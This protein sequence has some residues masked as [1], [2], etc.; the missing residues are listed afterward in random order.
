M[1]LRTLA[2]LPLCIASHVHTHEQ[3][4]LTIPRSHSRITTRSPVHPSHQYTVNQLAFARSF[5][6]LASNSASLAHCAPMAKVVETP[7][8]VAAIQKDASKLQRKMAKAQ[9]AAVQSV[10]SKESAA[11]PIET[12]P[13]A[14]VQS[15]S[16]TASQSSDA[17]AQAKRL[18]KQAKKDRK[19]KAAE[20]LEST[21]SPASASVEKPSV[22]Q[23]EASAAAPAAHSIDQSAG[24]EKDA[25]R[26]KADKKAAKKAAKAA[27]AST[28]TTSASAAPASVTSSVTDSAAVPV[29]SADSASTRPNFYKPHPSILALSESEVDAYRT[30]H[31]M[32]IS[33]SSFRPIQT[34]EQSG[35]SAELLQCCAQFDKPSPIQAQCW[36]VVLSGRDC[37]AIAET[38]SGKS[39]GFIMPM[40]VHI[41]A[42]MAA[43]AASKARRTLAIVLAPTRE[44]AMQIQ[45]VSE[46]AIA[47]LTL[48]KPKAV[49]I[50]GGVEKHIQRQALKTGAEL[51][52]ATPGRLLGLMAEGVIDLKHVKFAVL[53]EADRLLDL[54]FSDDIRAILGATSKTDRVLQLFSATWPD[55]VQKMAHEFT[56]NYVRINIGADKTTTSGATELT[57]NKRVK[58]TVEV[59]DDFK[60]EPRLH[61]LLTQCHANGKE[62]RVIVFVLYKKEVDRIEGALLRRGWQCIGI[63]GDRTQADRTAALAAFKEGKQ[64]IL[65]ATDVA[66]RGLDIANVEH[67]INYSFP[68]TVEGQSLSE[69]AIHSLSD[70]EIAAN[71]AK[72]CFYI[73][74]DFTLI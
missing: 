56:C 33:D 62:D 71:R 18:K 13:V 11:Q 52:V 58:Q 27:K 40:I 51:I 21:P 35:F 37:V 34:F 74:I 47:N 9:A 68:L 49:C 31:A 24:D 72:S 42:A 61:Q 41:Q 50:Y 22:E 16:T 2:R 46:L 19:R 25:K 4:L 12:K 7:A 57:A 53:D 60:R 36:P 17:A 6:P 44:L 29:S 69:R 20:T 32:T 70:F 26:R 3:H 54:G 15:A 8:S 48:N 64:R 65:I 14:T 66:A 73:C 38:G 59:I 45:D 39:L 1:R 28:A 43:Q 30:K 23:P 55:S 67:V 63:S 10:A 5:T